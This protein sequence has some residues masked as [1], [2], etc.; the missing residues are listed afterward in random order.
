MAT[1]NQIQTLATSERKLKIEPTLAGIQVHSMTS[2]ELVE[3][4]NICRKRVADAAG[5]AFPSKG[6]AKLEHAD[7]LKKVV[8]VLGEHAG[9]FSVMFDVEIGNGAVRKSPGYVFPKREAWLMAMSYS[10]EL[11]AM[12]FDR[13]V[14]LEIEVKK[15]QLTANEVKR[16]ERD[17][18]DNLKF[19]PEHEVGAALLSAV[20]RADE[21]REGVL[22]AAIDKTD[23]AGASYASGVPVDQI[24]RSVFAELKSHDLVR[25]IRRGEHAQPDY[26]LDVFSLARAII[27]NQKAAADL[28]A[29]RLA[30]AKQPPTLDQ[31]VSH[32]LAHK[33]DF[34]VPAESRKRR[35]AK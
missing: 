28:A 1:S 9:N 14:A 4:E 3:Y 16:I 31:I 8:E 18:A 15:L 20:R 17:Y 5:A 21:D 22:Y 32:D 11:Q 6:Y 12:V 25:Q 23:V 26:V 34:P 29:L 19:S 2:L 33:H 10:Y 13:A 30:R 35:R 27:A 24:R 7:F